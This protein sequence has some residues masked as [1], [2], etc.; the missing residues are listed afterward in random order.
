MEIFESKYNFNETLKALE[1]S[2]KKNNL[3]IIN[4]INA[5]ERLAKAGFSIKGNFIFEIFR[6]DYA[7]KIFSQNLKAGIEPPLRIYVF[8]DSDNKTYIEYYKPSEVFNKY[9]IKDI[10]DL[11]K[12][13]D[14]I[15]APLRKN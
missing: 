15:V 1:E 10:D 4:T 3:V 8:E 5:Q 13:F 12:I 6:P 2:I 7:Y 9:N 14:S 11:D